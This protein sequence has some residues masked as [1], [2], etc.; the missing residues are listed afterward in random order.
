MPGEQ[1][2]LSDKII[3]LFIFFYRRTGAKNIPIAVS[4]IYAANKTARICFSSTME[5]E[6]LL[7]HVNIYDSKNRLLLPKKCAARSLMDYQF[8]QVYYLR[9]PA[10]LF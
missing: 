1:T 7:A 3:D 6:M 5:L 10:F 9:Y 4:V 2:F 8:Y